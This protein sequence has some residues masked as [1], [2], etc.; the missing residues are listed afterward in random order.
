MY[1]GAHGRANALGQLIETA[2]LLR[3][4]G[5]ILIAC[6]GDGPERRALEKTVRGRGLVNIEFHGAVPKE[7]MPEVV[8]GCD[9]GAAVL[10]DNPTFRTVYPNKVFDYMACERPVLLAIDGVARELVCD[11]ARAGVFVQPEDPRAIADAIVEL[12]ELPVERAEMGRRG[13]RWVLDN[14]N[15]N[16]LAEHYLG[17]LSEVVAESKAPHAGYRGGLRGLLQRSP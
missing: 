14:A 3:E 15:R 12:A 9:L 4:R 17:I 16:T 13:R 8:N 2:Q 1:A 11:R 7:R 6:V 5:D 10:Q